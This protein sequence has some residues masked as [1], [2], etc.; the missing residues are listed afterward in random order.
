MQ[1]EAYLMGQILDKQV[2]MMTVCKSMLLKFGGVC[3]LSMTMHNLKCVRCCENKSFV[4]CLK[5]IHHIV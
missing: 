4:I 1:V 3:D 5:C 2:T